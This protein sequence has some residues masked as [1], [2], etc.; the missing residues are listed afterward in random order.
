[1]VTEL[2]NQRFFVPQLLGGSPTLTME[3]RVDGI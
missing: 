2:K 3:E 1:M